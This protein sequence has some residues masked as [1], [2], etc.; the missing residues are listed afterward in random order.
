MDKK[1]KKDINKYIKEI[2]LNI[3]CDFKTRNKFIS[4]IKNSIFD[5]VEC[6]NIVSID[7]VYNHF[8]TPQEIAKEFFLNADVKKIKRRMNFTKVVIVGVL[9]A[10]V[11]W[12]T[13]ITIDLIDSLNNNHGYGVEYIADP[14][15]YYFDED[16]RFVL[17]NEGELK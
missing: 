16:G 15:T 9:I 2:K 4:D 10:L 8:G 3:I 14:N 6:E 1:L 12:A 7:D 5:F 17:K 13:A 11:L